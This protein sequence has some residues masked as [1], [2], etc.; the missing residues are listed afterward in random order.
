MNL[1]LR[2]I[3]LIDRYIADFFMQGARCGYKMKEI[4]TNEVRALFEKIISQNIIA[5]MKSRFEQLRRLI[6]SQNPTDHKV[7]RPS[8]DAYQSE[9]HVDLHF[10]KDFTPQDD[11]S[12][13][14]SS[15]V[16]ARLTFDSSLNPGE[17]IIGSL[18]Q[19]KKIDLDDLIEKCKYFELF[20]MEN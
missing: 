15:G 1:K 11:T 8:R 14:E 4:V 19:Q 10:I 2:F 7:M 5:E 6:D 17:S 18:E 9:H 12:R 13:L 16:P 3:I 20:D